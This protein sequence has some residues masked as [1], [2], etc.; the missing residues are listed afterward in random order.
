MRG[1]GSMEGHQVV[2]VER[3]PLNH[4]IAVE[5][6]VVMV[7]GLLHMHLLIH[8][9][10]LLL[11][12]VVRRGEMR[13]APAS[14]RRRW[15]GCHRRQRKKIESGEESRLFRLHFSLSSR[16]GT[17][18]R[19]LEAL[20]F[21]CAASAFP[22]LA[23]RLSPFSSLLDRPLGAAHPPLRARGVEKYSKGLFQ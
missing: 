1:G 5:L 7:L 2:V 14:W 4:L 8:M 11:L 13:R 19:L 21:T 22:P 12:D 15:R 17:A 3:L 18:G 20:K 23:A 9:L 6:L 16:G 10:L